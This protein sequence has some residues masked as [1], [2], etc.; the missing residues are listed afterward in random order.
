[1]AKFY[2]VGIGAGDGSYITLGALRALREADIIAVPV[3]KKGEAS[4]ALTIAE[5]EFDTSK[6][7]ILELEFPMCSNEDII[8][9]AREAASG[10]IISALCDGKIVAMLTLGD[11]SVYSTCAYMNRAVQNAGFSA[12]AIAGVPSFIAAA[13]KAVISLCEGEDTMAVLPSFDI[14]KIEMC[15]DEFDTVVIMKAGKHI[16][17]IYDILKKRCME[18]RALVCCRIGMEG[19]SVEPISCKDEFG[20]FTT[21]IVRCYPHAQ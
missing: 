15:L 6:K 8:K 10:K 13:D 14:Q 1:M 17:S 2:S 7:V 5:K 21:V 3:R 11:V 19:E 9:K 16:A 18:K 20:Y 12:E 4:T